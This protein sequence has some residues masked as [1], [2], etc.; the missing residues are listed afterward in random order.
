VA[1]LRQQQDG[2]TLW[3]R[4]RRCYVNKNMAEHLGYHNGNSSAHIKAQMSS[5]E[6]PAS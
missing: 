1:L 6:I 3:I 2:G 4:Q 5:L